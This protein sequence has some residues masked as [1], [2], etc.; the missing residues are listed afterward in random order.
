MYGCL[1]GHISVYYL[2]A[3]CQKR[4]LDPLELEVQAVVSCQWVLGIEPWSSG[5]AA[6][7]L[8]H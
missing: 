6:S 5:R 4:A 8:D 7:V 2:C 3:C 1:S